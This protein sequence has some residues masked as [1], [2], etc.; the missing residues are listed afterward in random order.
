MEKCEN[1]V[2]VIAEPKNNGT[3]WAE[4]SIQKEFKKRFRSGEPSWKSLEDNVC[5]VNFGLLFK[6]F[7]PYFETF[8][9]Q[10]DRMISAGLVKFWYD[11]RFI[12]AKPFMTH[13]EPRVLT[14]DQLEVGFCIWL[15]SLAISVVQFFLEIIYSYFKY[16][17]VKTR[18]NYF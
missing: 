9:E 16:L 15:I 10:I 3:F 8:N 5:V 4:R 14:Y 11:Q 17:F 7:S 2:A 13:E 12:H 6:R 18:T 1:C